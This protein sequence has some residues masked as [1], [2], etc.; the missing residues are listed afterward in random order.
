LKSPKKFGWYLFIF[1]CADGTYYSGFCQDVD[2]KEREINSGV[3]IYFSKHPE[4]LPVKL[5]FEDQCLVFQEA[6]AKSRY[7][8]EMNRKLKKK[9]ILDKKW[10]VGG[11]WE[12]FLL[13][14][15]KNSV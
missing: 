12:K 6:Y 15:V 11:A 2:R 1:E 5:V 8:K 13:N 14:R 9:L 10:P 3:G 7:L 4:R